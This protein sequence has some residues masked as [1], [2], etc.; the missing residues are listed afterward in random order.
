LVRQPRQAG[1]T[2]K[3]RAWLPLIV[4][5]AR[6]WLATAVAAKSA[7]ETDADANTDAFHNGA[8]GRTGRT[9]LDDNLLGRRPALRLGIVNP[10]VPR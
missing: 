5:A 10:L 1:T 7:S 2:G 9:T 3:K 4:A 8:R 6:H